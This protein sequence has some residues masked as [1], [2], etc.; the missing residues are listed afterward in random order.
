MAGRFSVDG[1][2]MAIPPECVESTP[3]RR[4]HTNRAHS[5]DEVMEV[6][7]SIESAHFLSQ[8]LAIR[9][10]LRCSMKLEFSSTAPG[11]TWVVGC[12]RTKTLQ[13]P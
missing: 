6:M 4:S 8:C 9:L 2:S 5:Y 11:S 10:I 1:G 3:K 12:T 13:A 7:G